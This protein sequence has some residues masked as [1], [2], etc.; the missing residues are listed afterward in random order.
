MSLFDLPT[1]ILDHLLQYSGGL[2]EKMLLDIAVVVDRKQKEKRHIFYDDLSNLS[3]KLT[4]HTR[5]WCPTTKTLL[6]HEGDNCQANEYN[7]NCGTIWTSHGDV[8][9]KCQ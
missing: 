4:S 8:D 9:V 6:N 3:L 2:R 1:D 7:P 5:Q